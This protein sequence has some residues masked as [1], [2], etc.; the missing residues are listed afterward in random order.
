MKTDTKPYFNL[1]QNDQ[2]IEHL[3]ETTN[4][5][6]RMEAVGLY[7]I[8]NLTARIADLRHDYG[9]N[10]V[11]EIKKDHTGRRYARYYLNSRKLPQSCAV[12]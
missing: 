10:I 8:Y 11:T 4:G 9:L 6:T 1:S 2:L 12:R 7:R 5:I 3:T